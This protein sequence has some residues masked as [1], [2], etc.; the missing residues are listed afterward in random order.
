MF[1]SLDKLFGRKEAEQKE[2][3]ELRENAK[4]FRLP[5]ILIPEMVK[6]GVFLTTAVFSMGL[7]LITLPGWRG[8]LVSVAAVGSEA[9]VLYCY[10][11]LPRSAGGFRRSLAITGV[12]LSL[13][14]LIHSTL[15]VIHFTIGRLDSQIF[16]AY[17]H[18]VAFP[19]LMTCMAI[20]SIAIGFTHPRKV[21]QLAQAEAHTRM[22]VSQA[23][24]ASRLVLIDANKVLS[25]AQIE[26]Q[27]AKTEH[28]SLLLDELEKQIRVEERK[29]ARVA[30]I[31]NPALREQLARELNVVLPDLRQPPS[32]IARQY[33]ST[34]EW[35]Q[36]RGSS[37]DRPSRSNFTPPKP[38]AARDE[39]SQETKAHGSSDLDELEA[40]RKLRDALKMISFR[41]PGRS[42]KTNL[43]KDCIWIMQVRSH[44]GT[45][46]TIRSV[47]A[48]FGLLKAALTL[49]ENDFQARLERYLI[50]RDFDL[51]GE[52]E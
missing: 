20:G 52:S 2:M 27:R 38:P 13:L 22:A 16:N 50:E 37:S 26:E 47:K 48:S 9:L 4:S 45:Q 14:A 32:G 25:R 49:P 31:S 39:E 5:G 10:S 24:T 28:E 12:L 15:A 23:E 33:P 1:F 44:D 3:D 18:H 35:D 42:F 8:A 17:A 46:E 51:K 11:A 43:K 36:A 7:F 21:V 40:Q 19:L 30:A 41:L 34:G 29:I 6:Y